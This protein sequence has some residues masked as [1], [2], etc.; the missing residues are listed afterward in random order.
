MIVGTE[1]CDDHNSGDSQGCEDDCSGII[2][3]YYCS[4]LANGTHQCTE[5]CGDGFITHSE[6]CE[7]ND[8]DDSDGCTSTCQVLCGW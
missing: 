3:G 2:D 6:G 8:S 1:V 4:M 7:D 5:L